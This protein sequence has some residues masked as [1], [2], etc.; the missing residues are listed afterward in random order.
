MTSTSAADVA[1]TGLFEIEAATRCLCCAFERG[2]DARMRTRGARVGRKVSRTERRLTGWLESSQSLV[3]SLDLAWLTRTHKQPSSLASLFSSQ[4]PTRAFTSVSRLK[5]PSRSWPVHLRDKPFDTAPC[6]C[7]F[8]RQS[9]ERVVIV[10]TFV[11]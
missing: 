10:I 6:R 5:N 2:R 1:K 3:H 11:S 8:T 9:H 4:G 7:H